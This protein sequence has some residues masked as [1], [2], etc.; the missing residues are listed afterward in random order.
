MIRFKPH[1]ISIIMFGLCSCFLMGCPSPADQSGEAEEHVAQALPMAEEALKRVY[2]DA[3]LDKKSLHGVSGIKTGPDHG[4]TDWVEGHYR[5]GGTED[6]LINVKSQEI[7][8]TSEWNKVS[9]YAMKRVHELY[10]TEAGDMEGS[11]GFSFE[12]P[13]CSDS[14]EYGNILISDM[15]PIDAEVDDGFID[16]LLNGQEYH[17]TY[18]LFVDEDF[19]MSIFRETDH[20]PLGNNVRVYVEQYGREYL[21]RKDT[22]GFEPEPGTD[23]PIAIYDSEADS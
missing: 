7:Y 19:D 5:D 2:P 6:I 13:Y 10:D 22:P 20:S 17:K 9:S 11:V 8:T 3:M 23:E 4:L 14:D 21:K 12:A 18:Y 16:E 1:I 15:L